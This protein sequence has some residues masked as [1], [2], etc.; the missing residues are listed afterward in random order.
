MAPPVDPKMSRQ[1]QA[2]ARVA[3][4]LK[5]TPA[6]RQ[7]Y[8]LRLK[9][10]EVDAILQA[11][12]YPEQ[13]VTETVEL[14]REDIAKRRREVAG[15]ELKITTW[16]TFDDRAQRA[17]E[18]ANLSAAGKEHMVCQ[19]S[20]ELTSPITDRYQDFR[21]EATGLFVEQVL[22]KAA[23]LGHA[24]AE[25]T[26]AYEKKLGESLFGD[27]WSSNQQQDESTVVAAISTHQQ[28]L[29]TGEREPHF[30]YQAPMAFG[31]N[32]KVLDL[33]RDFEPEI[34]EHYNDDDRM[35]FTDRYEE[36]CLQIIKEK[37]VGEDVAD[38]ESADEQGSDEEEV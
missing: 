33:S 18:V 21:A 7:A 25:P 4:L 3:H 37:G 1:L 8:M 30:G 27:L 11:L 19:T 17:F 23:Q 6:E 38:D 5:L 10:N 2:A 24:G 14:M 26:N 15:R 13:K 12:K 36:N 22:R 9:S 34:A 35:V 28:Q 31:P 29:E 20:N 32:R 16:D